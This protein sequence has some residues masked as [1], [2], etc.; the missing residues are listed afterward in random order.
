MLKNPLKVFIL[1]V[2]SATN[3]L[4]RCDVKYYDR[5]KLKYQYEK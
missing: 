1:I 2:I 3:N 5:D 4:C